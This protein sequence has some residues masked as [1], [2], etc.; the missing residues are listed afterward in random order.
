MVFPLL[1]G[2]GRVRG[3]S[4]FNLSALFGALV[5][6]TVLVRSLPSA[7]QISLAEAARRAVARSP[8]LR[9]AD[10]QVDRA[11]RARSEA[12]AHRYPRLDAGSSL[13]RGDG[14]VYAF[15]SLL[16]QRS[17]TQSNFDVDAL[18]NPGYVTN[19][20][21]Y[22]RAGVPLFT[23]YELQSAGK[24]AELQVA[25]AESVS[26]AARQSLRLA[27]WEAGI[28]SLQARVFSAQ[29]AERVRSST[30]EVQSAQK[31]RD[32]GLVLGSDFFAAEAV[33]LGLQAWQI[34]IEKMGQA[35]QES[36]AVLLGQDPGQFSVA[37]SLQ[38]GGPPLPTL[39][40]LFNHGRVQRSDVKT[41][42]LQADQADVAAFK[43]KS[44]FLPTLDAMAQAETNTEDFSSNPGNRLIMVRALWALGDPSYVARR[45]K[46]EDESR[47]G[48]QRLSALEEQAR[49]DIVQQYRR[50]E[51]ARDSLPIF[52]Q[53]AAK[54]RQSLDLFRPLYR[55]GRQ[56]ILD[57][58]RAEEALARAEY[59]RLE[60]LASLHLQKA[61][62][63]AAA[64]ILDEGALGA[65][66][67]SLEK[68][69]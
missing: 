57:V 25:Q 35:A 55:E 31:L 58:L 53:T 3:L 46:A 11:R 2:E 45:K 59:L 10:A 48:R 20:K 67:A 12:G 64:G 27:V 42:A 60:T 49:V 5:L 36:L 24:M 30:Q 34:Q 61:R 66:S 68:P 43:E 54:A 39:P 37:G 56:S 50:Y 22:L 4:C 19:I 32:K 41:A 23:G 38:S 52:E 6:S 44:T 26:G 51:A 8:G 69:R 62:T 65:L 29:L 21:S 17:F 15:A 13:T 33:L 9:A 1:S 63:L 7:E 18:N 14:P 47:S 28:Q 40:D 16:D